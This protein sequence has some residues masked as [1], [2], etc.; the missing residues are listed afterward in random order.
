MAQ[1]KIL[2][3]NMY[4]SPVSGERTEAY[5]MIITPKVTGKVTEP[6]LQQGLGP[7]VQAYLHCLMTFLRLPILDAQD[8]AS[9]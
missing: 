2:E 9:S 3:I 6:G 1:K 7:P 5:G 8:K 4:P